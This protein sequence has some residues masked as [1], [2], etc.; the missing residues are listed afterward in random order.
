MAAAPPGTDSSS[1]AAPSIDAG[2]YRR[3]LSPLPVS[4]PPWP[5]ATWPVGGTPAIGC[6]N[7][8]YGPLMDAIWCGRD[9]K[10][11]KD[12]RFTVYGWIEPGANISTSRG[13]YNLTTGTGGNYPAAYSYEPNKI[14]FQ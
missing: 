6:E 11:W 12:S 9:G 10:K 8:T 14:R 3:G 5:D 4:V 7:I 2:G 1:A 13:H